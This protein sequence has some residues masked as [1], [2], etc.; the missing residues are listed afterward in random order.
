MEKRIRHDRHGQNVFDLDCVVTK[1]EKDAVD[2]RIIEA[3]SG[4]YKF[5]DA[6]K[7][8]GQKVITGSKIAHLFVAA[9][10][11]SAPLK[12][13]NELCNPHGLH[14]HSA[15]SAQEAVQLFGTEGLP[16]LVAPTEYGNLFRWTSWIER[17]LTYEVTNYKKKQT[18]GSQALDEYARVIN[19]DLYFKSSIPVKLDAAYQNFVKFPAISRGVGEEIDGRPFKCNS[20]GNGTSFGRSLLTNVH[21]EIQA[22]MYFE[23]RSRLIILHCI[24]EL[25][26][27]STDPDEVKE[28]LEELALP[29]N[30]IH[31]VDWL[32]QKDEWWKYSLVWQIYLFA[33][34]GYLVKE[35]R[36]HDLDAIGS[37]AGCSRRVV[38]EAL[39]SFDRLFPQETGNSWHKEIVDGS[40][41]LCILVPPSFRGIGSF[42]RTY[43][44]NEKD[45]MK[46]VAKEYT[47]KVMSEW[48]DAFVDRATRSSVA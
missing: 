19:H 41:E 9:E 7:V 31:F 17:S 38:S 6:F 43:I 40:I 10:R 42:V 4:K 35:K 11:E 46:F 45:I 30:A 23:H 16:A 12:I 26:A 27:K 2:Q 3:K 47:G 22:S 29:K 33:F 32:A 1:I 8:L 18:D 36:Q 44:Y 20:K 39:K 25:L 48:H 13:L 5:D 21:P 37:V 34:G 14:S 15:Q 28:Q 24:C